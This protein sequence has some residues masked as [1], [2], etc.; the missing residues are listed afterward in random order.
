MDI[1]G[2]EFRL[3][4]TS[5]LWIVHWKSKALQ[6]RL[7]NQYTCSTLLSYHASEGVTSLIP[8]KKGEIEKF[9]N[10]NCLP[11]EFLHVRVRVRVYV[12]EFENYI[13]RVTLHMNGLF[14]DN[15]QKLKIAFKTRFSETEPCY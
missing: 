11:N 5:P 1:L 13:I 10:W 15:I 4:F 8:S 2:C 6:K 9:I 7:S 14:G 3:T 12:W